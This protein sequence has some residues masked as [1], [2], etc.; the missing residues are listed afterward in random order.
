MRFKITFEE[1]LARHPAEVAEAIAEIRKSRSRDR[2][3]EVEKM[4]W[5]YSYSI[6]I[7]EESEPQVFA[8][9]QSTYK[10]ACGVV[11]FKSPPQELLARLAQEKAKADEE[12]RKE[13]ERWAAMTQDERD[14]E[15]NNL[16]QQLRGKKGFVEVGFK[17]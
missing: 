12:D 14:R 1:A 6:S 11:S 16:L 4:E 5:A 15:M 17:G 9:L 3:V 8:S 7:P 13:R 10:R 2:N